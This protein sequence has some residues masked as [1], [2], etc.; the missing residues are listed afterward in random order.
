MRGSE[1]RGGA[2]LGGGAFWISRPAL[3]TPGLQTHRCFQFLDLACLSSHQD[4]CFLFPLNSLSPDLPGVGSHYWG[5]SQVPPPQE[6][7]RDGPAAC[8]VSLW[9]SSFFPSSLCL[10]HQLRWVVL[11]SPLSPASQK[12]GPS[13][14][15]LPFHPQGLKNR[16]RLININQWIYLLTK[17]LSM[18]TWMTHAIWSALPLPTP[19]WLLSRPLKCILGCSW[20]LW[21]TVVIYPTKDGKV[22]W[23]MWFGDPDEFALSSGSATFNLCTLGKLINLSE[24]QFPH[25]SRAA[26]S[27]Q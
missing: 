5:F 16:R 14:S 1:K 12:L 18:L 2:S 4:I 27:K 21:K 3:V 26:F 11:R 8:V 10:Y 13:L 15:H 17:G 6:G 24:P 20:W 25:L 23:R 9:V 19:L 7:L 22:M